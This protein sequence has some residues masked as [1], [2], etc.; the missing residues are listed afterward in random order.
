MT[1]QN[2]GIC[3]APCVMWAEERSLK[4]LIYSSLAINVLTAMIKDFDAIF[5]DRKSVQKLI[6]SSYFHQKK[7]SLNESFS[8]LDFNSNPSNDS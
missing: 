3:I 7:K 8:F 5:G 4:D 2:V 1:V 6:R